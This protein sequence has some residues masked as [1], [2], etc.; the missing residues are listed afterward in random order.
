MSY[1]I[2]LQET[3]L[4]K[5]LDAKTMKENAE[6][7]MAQLK[8]RIVTALGKDGVWEDPKYRVVLASAP[9]ETVGPIADLIERFGRSKLRGLLNKSMVTTLRIT[10]R[11]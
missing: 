6:A 8:G 3:L 2:P 10:R 1:A 5:Y 9:R 11:A 4:E 7:E